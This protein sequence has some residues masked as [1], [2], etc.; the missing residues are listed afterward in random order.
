MRSLIT[1]QADGC[2]KDAQCCAKLSANVA[3]CHD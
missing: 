2:C 1:K 3:G